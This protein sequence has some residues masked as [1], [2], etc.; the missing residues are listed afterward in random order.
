MK[1]ATTRFGE[2]EVREET[3][4]TFPA[5]IIG[6]PRSTRYVV[7]DHTRDVPFKWLQSVDEGQL[8]FIIM[9]PLQFKPDYQI[10]VDP[11]VLSEVGAAAAEELI[12]FVILTV[13]SADPATVTANLRGPV[14]V[15]ERTRLAK[16]VILADELPTRY[17]V[18]AQQPVRAPV[19]V[20]M[21]VTVCP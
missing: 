3:F 17:P 2:L 20:A 1:I 7:L 9:D 12:C 14:V 11:D 16:Q 5:G 8:A 21:T 6:F 18:F 13:P 10:T 19:A 4:V 15:N